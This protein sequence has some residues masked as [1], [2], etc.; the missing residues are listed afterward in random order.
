MN[1]VSH[2]HFFFSRFIPCFQEVSEEDLKPSDH[3][4]ETCEQ[5][6]ENGLGLLVI[7]GRVSPQT[8]TVPNFCAICLEAYE[9]GETVVWSRNPKCI[10]AFHQGC[11]TACLVKVKDGRSTPCPMC[12]QDFTSDPAVDDNKIDP[13]MIVPIEE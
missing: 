5:D 1:V 2:P 10:H 8:E 7:P 4:D 9:P 3:V 6:I 13:A 11:I 12:R